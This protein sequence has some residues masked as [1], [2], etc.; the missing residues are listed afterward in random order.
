MSQPRILIVDSNPR[1]VHQLRDAFSTTLLPQPLHKQ[2]GESAVLWIGAHACDLC[3]LSYELPGI[4]GL[5]TLA[6]MRTR[7]PSLPVIMIGETDKQ[8]VPIAAFR[9]GVLDYFPATG[10]YADVVA[11]RAREHLEPGYVASDTMSEAVTDPGLRDVVRQRLEPTYQNRLRTIGRQVDLYG[12]HSICLVEIDGGFVLRAREQGKRQ[13]QALEFSDRDLSRLVVG[14]V[15]SQGS[16]D[17]KP[18][19]A[20]DLTPTGY[21]DMLRA[22]GFR[23]D[24]I[25]AEAVVIL[26]MEDRIIATGR[27]NDERSATPGIIPFEMV[28]ARQ[29]IDFMLNEAF[30]RRGT[31]QP[32]VRKPAGKSGGLKRIFRR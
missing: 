17:E 31:Q 9:S 30:Y 7:Q 5:E 8:H 10:R 24:Q 6:R 28:L 26:E 21:E 18:I 4:D 2:D 27:G 3:I 20:G 14:A 13:P 25:A 11:E 16:E 29:D 32:Q 23:L 1:R 15:Q 19:Y 12:Y 22:L